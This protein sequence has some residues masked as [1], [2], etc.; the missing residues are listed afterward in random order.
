MQRPRNSG[1]SWAEEKFEA[2][3]KDLGAE[4]EYVREYHFSETTNHRA[5]FAFPKWKIL[6]E[7]DGSIWSRRGGHST[8]RGIQRD[9]LKTN[10]AA[11]NG[12]T[13][14][15]FTTDQVAKEMDECLL[16]LIKVILQ[17]ETAPATIRV[18]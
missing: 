6:V 18:S 4:G 15:R 14:L 3:L 9:I 5:D 2:A 10:L 12:W 1:R 11:L 16:T 17:K 13:L 7:I 8:G